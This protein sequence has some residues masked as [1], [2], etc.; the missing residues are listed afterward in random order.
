MDKTF[1]SSAG[2][3]GIALG[4][5]I[6]ALSLV[7]GQTYLAGKHTDDTIAVT[8][9]AERIVQSD[10]V[11]WS[12]SIGFTTGV[13][14]YRD[15]SKQL[16]KQSKDF[17]AYLEKH[18]VAQKQIAWSAPQIN[19]ACQGLN[20]SEVGDAV[21]SG[22]RLVGYSFS[23]SFTIESTDVDGVSKLA[24]DAAGELFESGITLNSYNPEY[25]VTQLPQ[26]KLDMLD[27][28]TRNAHDR[29]ERIV[30]A[31]GASLGKLRS[32][33]MGVFQVTAVNS[34]E[35]S[36]YGA[37]DTATREKKITSIVRTAF[38]VK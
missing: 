16:T 2:F 17:E 35:I 34:T 6:V 21:C 31:S 11:K 3:A 28:A 24:Q 13:D 9:A 26:L 15:G 33:G 5:G 10:V 19:P 32:A 22:G 1:F 14:G 18:G 29:A 36:D 23:R 25:Y 27:E 4:A 38:D 20:D 7:G 30:K 37:Y 12:G 8:G